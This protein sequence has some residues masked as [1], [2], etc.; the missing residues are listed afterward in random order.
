M[1]LK[2]MRPDGL[3]KKI[4]LVTMINLKKWKTSNNMKIPWTI[5][6]TNKKS[7]KA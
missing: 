7:W 5:I 1:N 4:A 6:K 2:N 3:A